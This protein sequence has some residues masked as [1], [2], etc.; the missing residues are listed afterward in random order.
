MTITIGSTE[1]VSGQTRNSTGSPVGPDKLTVDDTPGVVRREFIGKTRI[2]PEDVRP[3]SG[4][5]SFE[6]HRTFASVDA[7]LAYVGGTMLAEETQG[8]FKIGSNTVFAKASV[9][10]RRAALVGCTVVVSYTIEG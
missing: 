4:S 8:A 2:E 10:K 6:A 7:A 9:T 3:H 5:V 1:L